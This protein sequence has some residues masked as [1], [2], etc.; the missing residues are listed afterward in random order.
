LWGA[1]FEAAHGFDF[2]T[3]FNSIDAVENKR[4]IAANRMPARESG[5]IVQS[6]KY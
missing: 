6:A 2:S 1:K 4:G 3:G 5:A